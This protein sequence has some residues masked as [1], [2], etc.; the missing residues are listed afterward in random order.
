MN[1]KLEK[2][3]ADNKIKYEEIGHKKV[4]TALDRAATMKVRPKLSGK[5]LI[6]KA[7]RDFVMA[8]VPANK[9]LNKEALRKTIN[10]FN[11]KSGKASV[12]KINFTTEAQIKKNFKGAKIGAIPPF[13]NIW[14][15]L[16][17]ADKAF[18]REKFIFINSGEY[19]KSLKVSPKIFQKISGYIFG[20]FSKSK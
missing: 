15:L 4:F 13:G 20:S 16:T 1:K 19:T 12:K 8:L 3:L 2:L 17:F 14:K 5:T 10:V 18:L 7:D 11:K 9:N 6:L